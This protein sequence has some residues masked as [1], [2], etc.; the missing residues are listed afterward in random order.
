ML[1]LKINDVK[2]FMNQLLIGELFTVTVK[3]ISVECSVDRETAKC[4]DRSFNKKKVVESLADQKLIHKIFNVVYFEYK[5]F[6][7]PLN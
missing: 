5:H 2:S 7:T 4:C 6:F 1:A 3:K